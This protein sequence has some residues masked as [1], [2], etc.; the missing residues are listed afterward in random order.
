LNNL[1]NW[2]KTEI[3]VESFD[4]F[5]CVINEVLDKTEK[6]FA[7]KLSEKNLEIVRHIPEGAIIRMPHDILQIAVRNLMSNAVKFSNSAGKIEIAFDA[8]KGSLSV[9]DFGVGISPEKQALLFSG[10]VNSGLGTNKEEGFG[11]GLYIV[12]ELV[13]KYGF[14]LKVES[15]EGEGTSFKIMP[16]AL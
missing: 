5:D 9:K 8:D 4:K 12:S 2:A 3:A 15:K 1:L 14:E 13:Y 11:I 7:E 16:A 10:Q 6:E